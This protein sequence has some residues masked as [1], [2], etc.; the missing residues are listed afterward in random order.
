MKI[1]LGILGVLALSVVLLTGCSKKKD[2][3]PT[4]TQSA[5]YIPFNEGNFWKYNVQ[6]ASSDSAAYTA[7][8]KIA[9]TVEIGGQ[10]MVVM[11][12]RK[13][14]SPNNW[15]KQFFQV[16]ENALLLAGWESYNSATGDTTRMLFDAPVTWVTIPFKENKTWTIYH[17]QGSLAD[18]P[19][20]SSVLQ[21]SDLDN[22]GKPE[23]VD[24]TIV[25]QSFSEETIQAA[26]K[27]FQ[28]VK[29]D[30]NVN[31]QVTMSQTHLSIPYTLKFGSFW[32][33]PEV[34]IVKIVQY[35]SGG[36]V[37]ETWLLDS[38]YLAPKIGSY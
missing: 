28:A 3:S 24:L 10:K 35:D 14:K 23:Q 15:M 2:E 8:M 1:R 34:G 5:S 6:P 27:S 12:T 19:L 33:A 31:A 20:A 32:F 37:I 18:A 29:I 21:S 9:G 7:T 25:G 13:S 36:K 4:K 30:I 26:G 22:D 38:Y 11:E 17:Y 16:T